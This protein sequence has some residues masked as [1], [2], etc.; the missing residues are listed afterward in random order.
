MPAP[1]GTESP[2]DGH[3][4]SGQGADRAEALQARHDLEARLAAELQAL[5]EAREDQ[6]RLEK[7]EAFADA[8][9]RAEAER[10]EGLLRTVDRAFGQ[11][12]VGIEAIRVLPELRM[13]VREEEERRDDRLAG[14]PMAVEDAVAQRLAGGA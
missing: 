14:D 9:A 8:A 3:R 6:R 12:A 2:V 1:S 5:T 13:A 4:D 10:G 7:G 11:E